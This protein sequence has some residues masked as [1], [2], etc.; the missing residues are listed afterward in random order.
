MRRVARKAVGHF[1]ASRAFISST[2]AVGDSELRADEVK[3]GLARGRDVNDS[4][5][6]RCEFESGAEVAESEGKRKREAQDF[7]SSAGEVPLTPWSFIKD[8]LSLARN[9]VEYSFPIR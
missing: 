7:F 5:E 6:V 9:R 4:R 8:H 3:V 2:W 1:A